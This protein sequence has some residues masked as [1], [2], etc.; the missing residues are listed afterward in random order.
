MNSNSAAPVPYG[1]A[2]NIIKNTAYDLLASTAVRSYNK[3]DI[4]L[5]QKELQ[6]DVGTSLLKNTVYEGFV[7][8]TVDNYMM[9]MNMQQS[10]NL[11]HILSEITGDFM[12]RY[13]VYQ[14]MRETSSW[15]KILKESTSVSIGSFVIEQ[16]ME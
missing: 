15:T 2:Q 10:R 7:R 3:G 11:V 1:N 13:V 14:L 12:S 4:N 8:P 9:S 6:L 16:L 5:N